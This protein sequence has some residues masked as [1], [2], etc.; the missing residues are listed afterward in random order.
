MFWLKLKCQCWHL[1]LSSCWICG[2]VLRGYKIIWACYLNQAWLWT[3]SWSLHSYRLPEGLGF[4]CLPFPLKPLFFSPLFAAISKLCLRP[5]FSSSCFT[6][7]FQTFPSLCILKV[8]VTC[9]YSYSTQVFVTLCGRFHNWM[10]LQFLKQ[11]QR[12]VS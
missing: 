5:P 3:S 12:N 4:S 11:W 7:S 10:L 8:S 6:F 2:F 1:I 9:L